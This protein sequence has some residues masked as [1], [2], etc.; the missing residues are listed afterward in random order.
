MSGGA[1][2]AAILAAPLLAAAA[3]Q[4]PVFPTE[5]R[6][7][8]LYATVKDSHGALVTDLDRAAFSVYENGR[9]QTISAFRRDEVPVSVGILIDNS[10]SMRDKRPGLEAAARAFVQTSKGQDEVFLLNFADKARVDVPFTS[11]PGVLEA[12]LRGLDAIGG[13]ALRDAVVRGEDY[14]DAHA[15]RKKKVL[16]VLT[17]GN[18]NASHATAEEIHGRAQHSEIVVYAAGILDADPPK[19]AR[20]REALDRLTQP[21]GGLAYYPASVTEAVV[22]ARDIAHQI[23]NQ[24]TIGYAPLEQALDGSYRKLKV[25]AKGRGRL[26]VRTRAGYRATPA[27]PR[28]TSR[29]ER[30][31]RRDDQ[32]S[33]E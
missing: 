32:E 16:L 29:S 3:A 10:R 9:L 25:V 23:R 28:G 6:E 14:L 15:A 7:V 12:G 27:G 24:Y 30:E 13:T 1:P 19:A 5:A 20:G 2:V 11:D 22:V 4:P 8:L 21:T 17:D 31:G 26:T 18:D 33:S